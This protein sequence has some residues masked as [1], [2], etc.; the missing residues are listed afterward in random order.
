MIVFT[1]QCL[2]NAV[3]DSP[4][5]IYKYPFGGLTGAL[6]S[7]SLLG[8]D[9]RQRAQLIL[10]RPFARPPVMAGHSKRLAADV[11]GLADAMR[12]WPRR[13]ISPLQMADAAD[14]A[15]GFGPSPG[16]GLRL[17]RLHP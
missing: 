7:K 10:C 16:G 3:T 15:G 11:D 8:D 6:A 5:S 14:R 17:R 13:M 9:D 2:A 4:L 1:K 12:S